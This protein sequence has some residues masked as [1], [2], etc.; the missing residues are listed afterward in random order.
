MAKKKANKPKEAKVPSAEK[1]PAPEPKP[2]E[3]PARTSPVPRANVKA[4]AEPSKFTGE[5]AR[6]FRNISGKPAQKW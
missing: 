1:A 5:A 3:E 4:P 6:V 2:P